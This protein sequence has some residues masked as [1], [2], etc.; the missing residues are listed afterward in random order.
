MSDRAPSFTSSGTGC[1]VAGR[2]SRGGGIGA[3]SVC[4]YAWGRRWVALAQSLHARDALEDHVELLHALQELLAGGIHQ[5]GDR[6]RPLHRA[7]V[8]IAVARR[9]IASA[10]CHESAHGPRFVAC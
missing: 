4:A 9:C 10:R 5:P 1:R 7:P 2:R 8:Q 3:L 6:E